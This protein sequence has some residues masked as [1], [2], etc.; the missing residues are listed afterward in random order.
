MLS[1]PARNAILTRVQ[2]SLSMR[3]SC[4]GDQVEKDSSRRGSTPW[5]VCSHFD[6][7]PQ[8][9]LLLSAMMTPPTLRTL[10]QMAGYHCLANGDKRAGR[11]AVLR[12]VSF[13]AMPARQLEKASPI[14]IR[15]Y[16]LE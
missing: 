5:Q 7:A 8:L 1:P 13:A 14:L 9:S 11:I 16:C 15:C 10:Q 12:F 4:S 6:K 2:K 3:A